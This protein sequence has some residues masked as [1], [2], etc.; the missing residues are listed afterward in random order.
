MEYNGFV[1][2]KQGIILWYKFYGTQFY[3]FTHRQ[4]YINA[5]V[6]GT[7]APPVVFFHHITIIYKPKKAI[8]KTGKDGGVCKLGLRVLEVAKTGFLIE[9]KNDLK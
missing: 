5:F 3:A 7:Q 2:C 8:L 6:L 9:C 1:L 4:S